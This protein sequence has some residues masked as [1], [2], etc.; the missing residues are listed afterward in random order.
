M[1]NRG[2]GRPKAE[3]KKEKIVSVRM[4]PEKYE[5]LKDLAD[6]S[7]TTITRI[8]QEGTDNMIKEGTMAKVIAVANQKGGVGKTTTTYNLGIG[9]VRKGKKV[10][11]I[12]A[13]AQ[14]DLTSCLGIPF[15]D[16]LDVTLSTVLANAIQEVEQEKNYGIQTNKEGVDF[17]PGNIDLANLDISLSTVMN[18]ERILSSYLETQKDRYDYILI[19]CSPSLG[20]LPLNCFSAA[21]SI[22]IPI[23]PS[24]LPAKGLEKLISTIIKVK[25][26]INPKLSIAGIVFTMVNNQRNISKD[27]MMQIRNIYEGQI[28]I[29]ESMIP[30]AVS[31]TEA[32]IEGKSIFQYDSKSKAAE[33]YQNLTEEVLKLYE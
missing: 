28:N 20:L 13:D 11:L 23:E 6:S 8:I 29:F 14:G 24:Y 32:P 16:E 33:A 25:K 30:L 22:I 17:M 7:N 26:N 19:D 18:R 2:C 31:V 1:A 12:D 21:D 4:V 27:T 5:Q 15:P 9:L 10:L 3:T